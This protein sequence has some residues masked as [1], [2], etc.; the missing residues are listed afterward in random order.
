MVAFQG[1]P[2]CLCCATVGRAR[3]LHPELA[4]CCL[5]LR[6]MSV[7]TQATCPLDP[8]V[9]GAVLEKAVSV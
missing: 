7:L 4:G 6:L 3:W 9:D 5:L 2:Q 8:G 1:L